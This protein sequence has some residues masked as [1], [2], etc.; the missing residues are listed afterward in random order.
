MSSQMQEGLPFFLVACGL[1]ACWDQ[2]SAQAGLVFFMCLQAVEAK[3]SKK[4]EKVR[5]H[6]SGA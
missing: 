2:Y 1:C 3:S 5:R 6:A 4:G